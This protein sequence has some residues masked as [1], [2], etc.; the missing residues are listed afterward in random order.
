MELW[1]TMKPVL[2]L[3]TERIIEREKTRTFI[4]TFLDFSA[5]QLMCR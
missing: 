1:D 3:N 2:G 5:C 4:V